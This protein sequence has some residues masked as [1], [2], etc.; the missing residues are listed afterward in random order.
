M[1]NGA[2]HTTSKNLRKKLNPTIIPFYTYTY[3]SVTL[4]LFP[5]N[6]SV[7]RFTL[8]RFYTPIY[9]YN[10]GMDWCLF[11]YVFYFLFF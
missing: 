7:N 1:V 8:T 4:E 10:T 11:I 5:G 9:T 3:V 2:L 6:V